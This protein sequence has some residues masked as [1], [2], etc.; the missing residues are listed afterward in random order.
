MPVPALSVTATSLPPELLADDRI[1]VFG[2]GER[3]GVPLVESIRWPRARRSSPSRRVR[4]GRPPPRRP[5]SARRRT[6]RAYALA[7][8]PPRLPAPG[9]GA[10]PGGPGH[11]AVPGLR[12]A[13]R[14]PAAPDRARGHRVGGR[15]LR[16]ADRAGGR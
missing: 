7:R 14:Q 6:R 16:G 2:T 4:G 9:P 10:A 15:A 1:R 5:G 13:P 11:L 12:P 3:R 8:A